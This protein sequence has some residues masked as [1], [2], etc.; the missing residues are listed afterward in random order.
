L[1]PLRS[2]IVCLPPI[3]AERDP[4]VRETL[5]HQVSALLDAH[6]RRHPEAAAL[7]RGHAAR[8]G[9]D[10]DIFGAPLDLETVRKVIAGEHEFGDW[11]AAM[12]D[13]DRPVDR[14]FEAAVDAVVAGDLAALEALLRVHLD[15]ATRR[16]SFGHRCTLLHYVAANGVEQTRQR[17]PENAPAIAQ[18]LLDAGAEPDAGSRSY[19][20][21]DTTLE[22]LV[23]SSHPGEAGVQADLVEI[24][25]RAGA[26]VEGLRGDGSPLWTA[27]TWG[28]RHAAERLVK[29]G[30]RVDNIITAAALGDLDQVK[31]FFGA[32]GRLLPVLPVR[33]ASCFTH[34]RPFDPARL[35][36]Y[37][38]ITA[39]GSGRRDVVEFLL[40]KGPDLR[41][42]EPIYKN[43]ALDAATYPHPAAGF[44]EGHPEVIRLLLATGAF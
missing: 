43:T 12:G 9:T 6:R 4:T 27:I 29:C 20:P 19:G 16:S 35:L 41:F 30:A 17:S 18:A 10:D 24:L 2:A 37:A 40:T 28:Y 34:G 8:S 25:C 3:A 21:E 36:E 5:E 15:L 23:S 13:G 1:T 33:G 11:A 7:L 32:D 14:V 42:R 44:P 38:L 39:A 26:K 31:S 22:L